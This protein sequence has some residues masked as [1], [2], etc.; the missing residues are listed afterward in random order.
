MTNVSR[1]MEQPR[2]LLL[3]DARQF[4]ERVVS[5]LGEACEKIEVAGS[6]RRERSQVGDIDLVAIPRMERLTDMFGEPAGLQNKARGV[7]GERAA[8]QGWSVLRD[9]SDIFSAIH[10]GVQLDVFWAEPE[11]WGT[12]LL[13]RTGSAEH[14]I[15][16]AQWA[17]AR[18]C[19]WNPSAGLYELNHRVSESEEEIY[20]YLGLPWIPPTHRNPE[21]LLPKFPIHRAKEFP[22]RDP[23]PERIHCA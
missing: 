14:N 2:K 10:K 5:W 11:N 1:Q 7:L 18:S 9:G 21:F 3:A 12:R 15:W 23:K 4:A 22:K 16:I 19:K 20:A 17:Q 6:I 13:C 8:T